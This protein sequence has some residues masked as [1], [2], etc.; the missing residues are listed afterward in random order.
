[1]GAKA[2]WERVKV[3][4]YS[5]AEYMKPKGATGISATGCYQWFDER[6]VAVKL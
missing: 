5:C 3:K 6:L 2:K 4:L 1:M